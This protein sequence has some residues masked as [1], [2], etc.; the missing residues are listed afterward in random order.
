M[1]IVSVDE[2]PTAPLKLPLAETK[3][4]YDLAAPTTPPLGPKLE[5]IARAERRENKSIGKNEQ[6]QYKHR[7][8]T[9]KGQNAQGETRRTRS[10]ERRGLKPED[11]VRG[12]VRE[13][14][15]N[16]NL[17]CLG[18]VMFVSNQTSH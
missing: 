5:A 1:L 4:L 11:Y 10:G 9:S 16:A 18:S 13:R 8:K 12:R 7:G 15:S 3:P 6:R 14:G 17:F 2:D